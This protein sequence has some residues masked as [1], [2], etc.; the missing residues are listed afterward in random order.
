MDSVNAINLTTISE[1][2]D[3]LLSIF[4]DIE[5][6]LNINVNDPLSQV[7]TKLVMSVGYTPMF[8][9]G[10]QAVPYLNGLLNHMIKNKEMYYLWIL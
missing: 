7:T 10:E 9:L 5:L 2:R 3:I 4:P 8:E 1:F 6:M